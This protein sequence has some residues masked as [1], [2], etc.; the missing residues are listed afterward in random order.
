MITNATSDLQEHLE[1]IDDKLWTFSQRSEKIS[2]PDEAEWLE[3]QQEKD[4]TEKCLQICAQVSGY[5][6][7]VHPDNVADVP[8]TSDRDQTT[9]VAD[10]SQPPSA[11]RVVDGTLKECKEKLAT[12]SSELNE[13]VQKL[14]D[15]L[16]TF[17]SSGVRLSNDDRTELDQIQ[18]EKDSLQQCLAIC[19]QASEK[20][21][22]VRMNIFEDVTSVDDAQQLIVST[23]GDL[24]SAKRITTGSRSSQWLGQMSD[25]TVQ[26]VSRD[27]SLIG[28]TLAEPQSGPSSDEFDERYGA[29]V[30]LGA[31]KRTGKPGTP[32]THRQNPHHSASANRSGNTSASDEQR[33]SR[34]G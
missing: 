20:T 29:G 19:N 22:G 18:E 23:L 3:I 30:Q 6:N 13:R 9:T 34:V 32:R 31:R 17:L 5:I 8:S 24:I 11:K 21:N 12:T 33:S 1:Q 28:E 4:S 16:A 26:Q 27:R 7:R 2:G 10:D 14:N 25:D 15:R